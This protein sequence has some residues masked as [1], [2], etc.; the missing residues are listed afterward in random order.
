M[1]EMV[2]S[3]AALEIHISL[4]LTVLYTPSDISQSSGLPE[5]SGGFF[6]V[7]INN[8]MND[9]GPFKN[10]SD[11]KRCWAKIVV[12]SEH[13]DKLQERYP[14]PRTDQVRDLIRM[15][16]IRLTREVQKLKNIKQ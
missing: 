2:T 10:N 8:C 9:Q 13:I 15:F 3:A 14:S 6:C 16:E 4:H 1:Q 12:L 7:R 11:A 5:Q